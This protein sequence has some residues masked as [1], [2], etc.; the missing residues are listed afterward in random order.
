MGRSQIVRGQ[1]SLAIF[2]PLT[3][4]ALTYLCWSR[5]SRLP[6]CLIVDSSSPVPTHTGG[7]F[8]VPQTLSIQLTE[9]WIKVKTTG[10]EER[11][12]HNFV[13]PKIYKFLAPKLAPSR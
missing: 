10:S 11:I 4:S 9:M 2:N 1:E 3:F 7:I 8:R 12:Q 6:G 13:D 5:E